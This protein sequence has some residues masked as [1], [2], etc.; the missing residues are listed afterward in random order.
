MGAGAEGVGTGTVGDRDISK[1]R[2]N[3]GGGEWLGGGRLR[4][5]AQMGAHLYLSL[6]WADNEG[7]RWRTHGGGR[8]WPC[9]FLLCAG[10]DGRVIWL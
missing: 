8:R 1:R 7:R 3:Q 6:R 5:D 2:A 4:T 10:C 9:G